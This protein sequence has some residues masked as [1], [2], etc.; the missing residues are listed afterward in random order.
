MAELV[1]DELH[2]KPHH[3]PWAVAIT[4]TLA[5][6]ME[7]LDTSIANVALPHM[8]GIPG[9]EP[10]RSD[11][12]ADQLPGVERHHSADLRLAGEPHR[13]QALLH[14]LRG[15]VH[16][17]LAAVRPGADAAAADLG[18]RAAG[19]GRRRP[20]AQRAGHPGGYLSDREARAGVRALWHGGGVRAGHRPHPRRLDHGQLQLALD[21][22]HQPAGRPAVALSLQPHG[23]GP[24][25]PEG[26]QGGLQAPEG[27]LHGPGTGRPRRRPAGVHAGQGPGEGL[28]RRSR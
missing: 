23:G 18:A 14:V 19:P 5:T 11:L 25:V 10:G 9:R 8:A 20:R 17:L 27:R 24:A 1:F 15:D 6:F 26:A 4:V 2:W 7:V 21:L 16:G 12:G 13:A 28:V 3:N 22:L